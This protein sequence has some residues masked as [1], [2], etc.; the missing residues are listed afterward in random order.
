MEVRAIIVGDRANVEITPRLS[1]FETDGPRGIVR[2]SAAATQLSV[3]LGQWVTIGGTDKKNSEAFRE[4][5]GGG[6]VSRQSSFSMEM[7]VETY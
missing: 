2:Y 3:P 1:N 4:I 6:R 7:M 5:I